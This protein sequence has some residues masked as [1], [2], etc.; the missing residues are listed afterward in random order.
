MSLPAKDRVC[1]IGGG[2]GAVTMAADLTLR[3]WQ[4]CLWDFPAFSSGTISA[5]R[6]RGGIELVGA[7]EGFA[8]LHPGQLPSDVGEALEGADLVMIIVPAYGHATAARTCAPFLRPGQTVVVGP[9]T[10]GAL[11]VWRELRDAGVNGVPVAEM[12]S[13]IYTCRLRDKTTADLYYVKDHMP[14]GVQ[15]AEAREAVVGR[16]RQLYP[17]VVAATNV[18][19]T[20][21]NNI[22]PVLH[23]APMLLNLG[24]IESTQGDFLFYRESVTESVGRVMDSM[25]EERVAL[26]SLLGFDR[27]TLADF[28]QA[29]YQVSGAN[30][31][32]LLANSP[33]HR[34]TRAP[35]G[36]GHRY[37]TEDIPYGLVPMLSIAR[38]LGHKMPIT[39]LF[40]DLASL[41]VHRD[42]GTEGRTAEKLGIAG[43]AA[44]DLKALLEHGAYG[45]GQVRA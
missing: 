44:D 16:L 25:D 38:L 6:Q 19:E 15:P 33:A 43:L 5:I 12:L 29:M 42:F 28:M 41:L 37:V 7:R 24:R 18:L 26:T 27:F 4:V 31:E 13:L 8:V 36:L 40:V 32:Q 9:S 35:H 20:S 22:N 2:N 17:Q 11:E 10:G 3:G 23:V 45:A 1:V 14:I 34:S 30:A 39:Q 21:L